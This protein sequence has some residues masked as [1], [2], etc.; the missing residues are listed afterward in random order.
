MTLCPTLS[1]TSHLLPRE[2]ICLLRQRQL[3][4]L[5]LHVSEQHEL[6][7]MIACS[8]AMR[9][10]GFLTAISCELTEVCLAAT[11]VRGGHTWDR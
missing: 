3:P 8:K 5:A 1:P 4:G 10:V 11:G 2:S 6:L 7:K 9:N